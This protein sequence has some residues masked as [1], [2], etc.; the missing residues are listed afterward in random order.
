[1]R[2]IFMDASMDQGATIVGIGPCTNLA[3]FEAMRPGR[4]ARQAAVH[5]AANAL[6]ALGRQHRLLPND[7]LNFQHD[8]PARAV[9]GE[10]DGVRVESCALRPELED[11]WLMLHIDSAG[12]LLKVLTAVDGPRF[13]Q[14][15]LD[16]VAPE[17]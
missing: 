7:L 2:F 6:P 16:T 5:G 12:T 10:R 3:R 9:A 17:P 14:L 8:P 11:G 1:M 4:L 15:W 13:N